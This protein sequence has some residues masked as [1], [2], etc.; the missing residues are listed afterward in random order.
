MTINRLHFHLEIR[1]IT[2]S[3]IRRDRRVHRRPLKIID[4]QEAVPI[5]RM[6]YRRRIQLF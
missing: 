3:P 2:R 1:K 6:Y 5:T 4:L